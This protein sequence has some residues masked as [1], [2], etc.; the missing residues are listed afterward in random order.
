MDAMVLVGHSLGGLVS[1]MQVTTSYDLLWNEI[2]LQPFDAL[3]ASPEVRMKLANALF[4]EPVPTVT[5]VVFIGTPHQGSG[6]TRRLAGRIGS[7]LVKFGEQEDGE[8]RQVL[9][10]NR[11]LFKPALT[12]GR[13]TSINLLDPESPFLDGL[14]KMPVNGATRLHSIIGT[15]GAN[16]LREPGDGVVAVSS[17]RHYGDSEIL[18]PAKH[19][20]LHRHPDSIN[21]VARILR[22]HASAVP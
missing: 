1:K 14:A 5:R 15:G 3:R 9:D 12:R 7:A 18:V 22:V 13:P 10:D 19:E 17:A 6:M 2:A 11:G 16:P 4:Y 20:K 21:E 8:Y